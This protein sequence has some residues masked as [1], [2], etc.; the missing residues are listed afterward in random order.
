MVVHGKSFVGLEQ[1]LHLP[2]DRRVVPTPSHDIH[3]W[4]FDIW[5]CRWWRPVDMAEYVQVRGDLLI[6]LIFT[7]IRHVVQ[8]VHIG[9]GPWWWM[10][11]GSSQ[12]F[13]IPAGEA[14]LLLD[15][16]HHLHQV[17]LLSR[18]N[19]LVHIK[20][21][22]P[23]VSGRCHINLGFWGSTIYIEHSSQRVSVNINMHKKYL[24][25]FL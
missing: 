8:E 19:Y 23:L 4:S 2:F 14:L 11:M 21:P 1:S 6:I 24:Y 5:W 25:M 12:N 20:Q 17:V 16:L 15:L 18:D 3:L 9:K 22:N 7:R 13:R 10:W